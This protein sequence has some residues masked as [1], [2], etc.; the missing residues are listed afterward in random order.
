MF[1]D[2]QDPDLNYLFNGCLSSIAIV[3]LLSLIPLRLSE[4]LN[5]WTLVLPWIELTLYF[6]NEHAMPAR[7]GSAL[8]SF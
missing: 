8:I 7:M 2:V 6:T 3:T 5:R 1:I 4:G